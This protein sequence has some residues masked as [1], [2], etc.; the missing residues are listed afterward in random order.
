MKICLVCSPGG[1]LIECLNL[2]DAFS[3]EDELI[4][5]TQHEDFEINSPNINKIYFLKNLIVKK[6]NSSKI[7]KMFY[8]VIS[9]IY[10]FIKAFY[11]LLLEKPDLIL[12]TGS[13][14][15]I[16]FF[17]IGKLLQIKTIFIESLTRI[18]ELSGTGKILL[19]VTDIF[20]VQWPN[21][22]KKYKNTMYKGNLLKSSFNR[23]KNNSEGFIFVTVGTAAFERLVEQCDDLAKIIDNKIIIQKG[24]S[25]YK[26]RNVEYFDFTKN[27]TEFNDLI[28][29]A[30][31]VIGHAGVGTILN[32][33][34][35]NTPL[36][37]VPRIKKNREHI[38]NHQLELSNHLEEYSMVRVAKNKKDILKFL[39]EIENGENHDSE[40]WE[41]PKNNL[42]EFLGKQLSN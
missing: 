8:L 39:K 10:W 9:M 11:I 7:T 40:L 4:L 2:L 33:L 3:P 30:N 34:G 1:H 31:V 23:E 14:I 18:N 13:E 5:V 17:Y 28:D 37:V 26:P 19:K 22:S 25:N 35:K 42:I 41:N 24:R 29:K 6:V 12:S 16:P 15:A 27:L 21:L 36:I 20:L 32:V 38:D